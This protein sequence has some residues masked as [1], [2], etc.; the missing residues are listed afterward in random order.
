MVP[1]N[2]L[3]PE[4]SSSDTLPLS[5]LYRILPRLD[6]HKWKL[7]LT[8]ADGDILYQVSRHPTAPPRYQIHAMQSPEPNALTIRV[9]SFD[10]IQRFTLYSAEKQHFSLR[11][12]VSSNQLLLQD[13]Q[14]RILAR[15]IPITP[16]ITL[17]RSTTSRVARIRFKD[18][19][20]PFG[21]AIECKI[22]QPEKWLLAILLYV[23]ER[24]EA[25]T[26]RSPPPEPHKT[27]NELESSK[28]DVP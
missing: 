18:H 25:L 27:E 20:S 6:T 22:N 28:V 17:M 24:I 2:N 26:T 16:E 21:I 23:V 13:P 4:Q 8:N 11:S 9:K 5:E 7:D 1:R 12:S 15:F 10:G 3:P 19:P 14:R